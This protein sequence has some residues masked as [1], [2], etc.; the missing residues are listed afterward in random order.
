MA[1]SPITTSQKWAKSFSNLKLRKWSM[2]LILRIRNYHPMSWSKIWL[3]KASVSITQRISRMENSGKNFQR[4]W[5]RGQVTRM[6]AARPI[7][8]WRRSSL[9]VSRPVR[10]I[11]SANTKRKKATFC[12]EPILWWPPS[13][14]NQFHKIRCF[15]TTAPFIRRDLRTNRSKHRNQIWIILQKIRLFKAER[16]AETILCGTWGIQWAR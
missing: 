15:L 1:M 5:R 10:K 8:L 14:M 6:S 16:K 3:S 12:K 7:K 4:H 2:E 11:K 13:L 9:W